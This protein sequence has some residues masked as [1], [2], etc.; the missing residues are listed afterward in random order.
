MPAASVATLRQLLERWGRSEGYRRFTLGLA[1]LA[2]IEARRLSP[3][4]AKIAAFL[5]RNGERFYDFEGLRAFKARFNPRWAP[6]YVAGPR[7]LPFARALMDLK[8]L[9]G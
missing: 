2:G 8:S 7:G 3:T 1:P 9:I 5:F 4:W 6:R